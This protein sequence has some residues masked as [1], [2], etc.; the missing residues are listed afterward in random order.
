MSV[1]YLNTLA[2]QETINYLI[3]FSAKNNIAVSL[4]HELP[5]DYPSVSSVEDRAIYINSN[6]PNAPLQF[7]HELGHI[8]NQDSG[9]LYFTALSAIKTEA[10]ATKTG[11]SILLDYYLQ[12]ND[13]D[14][15]NIDNFIRLYQVPTQFVD[16]I[17][18]L[19]NK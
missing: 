13:I 11:L 17:Y 16:Y 6:A 3:D 15:F 7:A 19:I 12:E 14:D 9:V 5:P 1:D 8:L 4:Q 10:E 18:K 2:K